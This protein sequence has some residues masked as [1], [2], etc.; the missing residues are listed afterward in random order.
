MYVR[1]LLSDLVTKR[2]ATELITHT[3]TQHMYI[4]IYIYV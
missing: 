1:K 2:V 4:Y 3:H